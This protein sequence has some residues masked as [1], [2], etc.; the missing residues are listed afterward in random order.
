MATRRDNL[1]RL[2]SN[3]N[4]LN[5]ELAVE[6]V[7]GSIEAD[8]N[9]LRLHKIAAGTVSPGT[10]DRVIDGIDQL[11]FFTGQ[12]ATSNREGFVFYIKQELRADG[13]TMMRLPFFVWAQLIT[14]E[15]RSLPPVGICA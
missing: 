9:G 15:T 3:L 8:S 11:D 6:T 12:Q 7:S 2:I 1:R 5:G 13:L 4:K 10:A 14:I